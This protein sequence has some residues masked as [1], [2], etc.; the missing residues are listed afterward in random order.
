M[1]GLKPHPTSEHQA[2]VSKAPK[3]E[4]V[5]AWGPRRRRSGN[6]QPVAVNSQLYLQGKVP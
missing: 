2:K 4:N 3:T 1:V 6:T 5:D